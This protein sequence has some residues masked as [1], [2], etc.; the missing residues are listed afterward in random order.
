MI[1]RAAYISRKRMLTICSRAVLSQ[2]IRRVHTV[3]PNNI[4]C[5]HG[6]YFSTQKQV[7]TQSKTE[8]P[9]EPQ[10]QDKASPTLEA[11]VKVDKIEN[12]EADET[13]PPV[14]KPQQGKPGR[15]LLFLII[16]GGMA[17][18]INNSLEEHEEKSALD[19]IER[20]EKKAKVLSQRDEVIIRRAREERIK[21]I[22][23]TIQQELEQEFKLIPEG[24]D[25][26]LLKKQKEINEE[27][28]KLLGLDK[29]PD[30]TRY[31]E[32]T[33]KIR[34]VHDEIQ[35]AFSGLD[36]Q[37]SKVE[38]D[39]EKLERLRNLVENEIQELENEF[40]KAESAVEDYRKNQ[41]K[42]LQERSR[43]FLQEF[44]KIKAENEPMALSYL[45]KV[46]E[47]MEEGEEFI[48]DIDKKVPKDLKSV[49]QDV[50]SRYVRLKF[51]IKE[52]YRD[53][54]TATSSYEKLKKYFNS[55]N[56]DDFTNIE[57]GTDQMADIRNLKDEK[58]ILQIMINRM[59]DEIR[60]TREDLSQRK[61]RLEK[62]NHMSMSKKINMLSYYNDIDTLCTKMNRAKM[63]GGDISAD[64]K[65]LQETSQGQ[66]ELLIAITNDLLSKYR[67]STNVITAKQLHKFFLEK[68]N[69][70][71]WD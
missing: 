31:K 63:V 41:F 38:R 7:D 30:P 27:V 5:C 33:E 1:L 57:R 53:H 20:K 55:Y 36:I 16:F 43:S 45:H 8:T 22:R 6:R 4:V 67:T 46:K 58:A 28:D 61:R 15:L 11:E 23:T 60:I 3:K 64:L 40:D 65:K 39:L 44:S 56:K 19:G 52:Y 62:L 68:R 47:L 69:D 9:V 34:E 54:E 51:M 21:S 29:I 50:K 49:R 59:K 18:V 14:K 35:Q 13:H 26:K 17:F 32:I 24:Y 12:T 2:R 25:I 66:D 71:Y 70:Y 37:K 10:A 42:G 48:K